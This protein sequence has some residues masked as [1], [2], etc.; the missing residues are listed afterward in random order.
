MSPAENSSVLIVPTGIKIYTTSIGKKY[1]HCV[2][3]TKICRSYFVENYP[4]NYS[5]TDYEIP[6]RASNKD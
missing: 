1:L 2:A 5:A 4:L 6:P 3:S